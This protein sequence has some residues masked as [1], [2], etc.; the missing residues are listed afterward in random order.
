MLKFDLKRLRAERVANGLTQEEM[1]E[2]MGY[3]SKST[4]SRKENGHV[5]IGVDEFAKMI[6]IFGYDEGKMSIFF[7]INVDNRGN[8]QWA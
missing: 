4:Y 5:A 3:K 1:A 7:T 8:K 2:A 6:S